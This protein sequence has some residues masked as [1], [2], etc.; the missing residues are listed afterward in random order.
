MIQTYL[1]KNEDNKGHVDVAVFSSP[2]QQI[3]FTITTYI[4]RPRCVG[5]QLDYCFLG[6]QLYGKKDNLKLV[7]F[8]VT[9]QCY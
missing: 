2:I 9:A 4:A 6:C 5:K 8:D 3:F 1:Y 7:K